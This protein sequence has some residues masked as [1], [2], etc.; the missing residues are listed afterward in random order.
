MNWLSGS[1]APKMKQLTGRPWIAGVSSAMQKI[2]PFILAASLIFLYNVIKSYINFLPDLSKITDFT[3]GLLGVLTA[4]MMTNQI[5]E[6]LNKHG[7]SINAALV[8]ICVFLI[9]INPVIDKEG[10]L[11]VR[12]ERLGATGILVGMIAGIFVAIIFNL[13]SKLELLRESSIPDFVVEWINNIIPIL[14]SVGISAF[15]TFKLHIDLFDMIIKLFSPLQS[16]GQT[17]P[18]FILICFIP[19]FLYSMG[20]SSWLF[21]AVSTPI[22]MA[23]INENIEAVKQGLPAMNIVTSETVFTAALITMG[24]MGATLTLNLLMLFSKS[25]ELNTLGKIC[26]VPSI[27]NINEPIMFSTPVV[28]NPLLML[29]MWIN[30]IVGPIVLWVVM[31]T[32]LLNI[33][34]KMI[35][36]GQVPAPV[37]S[38]MITEDW[39]AII[40]YIV[41]FILYFFIWYPFFKVYE[42]EALEK[43]KLG[44]EII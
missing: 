18:G 32:N 35:Q 36:V 34:N 1:F 9:F 44:E 15:I 7:Y 30:S 20:I 24:G 2:I 11:V 33:P 22:F 12:F 21:G 8:A 13:W 43:E 40:W 16:F 17:L 4:F 27:F 3:F 26:I 37:S 10:M 29:P 19:A 42:K 5:M 38:V 14:I 28:M 31:K 39:R 41:L 6:K 23:G 25:K